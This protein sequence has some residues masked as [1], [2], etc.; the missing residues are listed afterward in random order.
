MIFQQLSM[1]VVLNNLFLFLFT[2]QQCKGKLYVILHFIWNDKALIGIVLE[3]AWQ[4]R[5][6]R[7]DSFIN[8]DHLP[9]FHWD[10]FIPNE[11]W[12]PTNSYG[13]LYFFS[14]H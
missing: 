10:A 3:K 12:N 6:R 11:A 7:Q 5:S 4:R 8:A 13:R 1:A 2:N 14:D 9:F